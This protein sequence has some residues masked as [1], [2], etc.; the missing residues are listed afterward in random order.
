MYG[1]IVDGKLIIAGKKI[2]NGKTWITNPNEK[3]LT[4]FGYKE[5]H[6]NEKPGFDFENEALTEK[7]IEQENKIVV[8]YDIEVLNDYA[9]NEIIK[10]EILIEEA[11]ITPRRQREIDLQNAESLSEAQKVDSNIARLREK[12]R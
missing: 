12:F 9:H 7:Y 11:K 10:Q 2:Q 3:Q 4:R 6:Y 1:K 5:V 8:D